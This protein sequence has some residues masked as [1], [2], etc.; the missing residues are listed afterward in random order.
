MGWWQEVHAAC[1]YLSQPFQLK[2][3]GG[4]QVYWRSLSLA[5]R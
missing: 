3:K 5:W 1:P 2:R 4:F